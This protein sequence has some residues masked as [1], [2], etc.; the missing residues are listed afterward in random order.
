MNASA[1]LVQV[2]QARRR[3]DHGDSAPNS[4]FWR[5]LPSILKQMAASLFIG[6]LA[7]P[8]PLGILNESR[9]H[10]RMVQATQHILRRGICFS[11]FFR[12][13]LLGFSGLFGFLLVYAAFGGFLAFRILCIPSSSSAGGVLAFSL[14]YA[15]FGG[16][17]RLLAALGFRILRAFW[18]LD[19]ASRIIS[20]TTT[21]FESSL[22][23]TAWGGNPNL[24]AT[25]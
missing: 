21:L 18:L 4:T 16:F 19:L 23:R 14:V 9:R 7:R 22:L 17:W 24:P 10:K 5:V 6:N 11:F 12:F 3:F 15:A 25:V 8:L 1:I 13:W 2:T 20:I